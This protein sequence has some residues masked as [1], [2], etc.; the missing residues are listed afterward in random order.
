MTASDTVQRLQRLPRALRWV[1][2]ARFKTVGLSVTPVLCGTWLA[3]VSGHMDAALATLTALSAAA[4]QVGTN[5][6]NDA[7]DAARG[8]DTDERL[9]PPR[10][11]ALGL[12]DGTTVRKAAGLSFAMAVLAGL[13]LVAAGGWPV[14]AVG[15]V[16][17][18]LGYAYSMGPLPL[19]HTPTGEVIVILFFGVVAV[20]GTAFVQGAEMSGDVALAGLIM[21]LPSSAVLLLNNHRDRHTDARAGRKTLAILLGVPGARLLYGLLLLAAAALL[22]A[23]PA[24]RA[25]P[26]AAMVLAAAL[27]SMAVWRTPVSAALN[28]FLPLTVFYQALLLAV[29]VLSALAG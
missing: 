1:I 6:W 25:L 15:L 18:L 5:L 2:A 26:V 28:R 29:M 3:H 23:L 10:M 9:G 11:T 4:I 27:L 12:L 21:G 8:T 13:P 20:S 17:L 16:S 22:A 24:M 7:A 14:I 19:S